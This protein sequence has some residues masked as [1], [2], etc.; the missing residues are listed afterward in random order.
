MKD[1][2]RQLKNQRAWYRRNKEL[3]MQKQRDTRKEL[4]RWFRE[5]VLADAKCSRCNEN[6]PATFDFHHIDP[7]TKEFSLSEMSDKKFSK[8]RVLK[9]LDKCEILCANCHRKH[10]FEERVSV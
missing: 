6:H 4:R 2:E 8:E 3:M 10:H 1:R 7:S 9:E 5:E